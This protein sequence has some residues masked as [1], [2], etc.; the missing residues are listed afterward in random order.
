M[1]PICV[2]ILSL[3][4]TPP[5]PHTRHA[6]LLDQLHATLVKLPDR[7]LTAPMIN[8]TLFP[9]T[10]ILRQSA[11]TDLPD[12]FLEAVFRVLS[13]LVRSWRALDGGMDLVAWEQLWRFTTACIGPGVGKGKGKERSQ[14]VQLEAVNLLTALLEPSGTQD[15]LNDIMRAKFSTDRSPLMPTLFQ[16]I[17]LLLATSSPDPP[18]LNLQLHS[19][20]LLRHCIRFLKGQHRVLASVLP[21]TVSAMSR[22]VSSGSERIKGDVAVEVAGVVEEVIIITVNDHDLRQL[23][24]LQSRVDDLSQLGEETTKADPQAE[25]PRPS[26]PKDP[27]PPLTQ[28]YLSFTST[29]LA[30]VVP[31][32][33]SLSTHQSSAARLAVSSLAYGLV[34]LCSESLALDRVGL[35]TLL[36]LSKDEF[37]TVRSDAQ[38]KLRQLRLNRA[39]HI[40]LVDILSSSL[41]SLPRLI[42]SQQ[43]EKAGS[44]ARLITALAETDVGGVIADLLGPHGRVER[45]GW[46]LL[47]CLEF[48]KPTGS[49]VRG[50][51][52][53]SN[54]G[55][56]GFPHLPLR[57]VESGSTTRELSTMLTSLGS[58][59]GEMALNSVEHFMLFAKAHRGSQIA[60][61][62]SALWVADRL[63]D[64][65]ALA[66]EN[67]IDGKVSKAVRKMAR[68]VARTATVLDEDTEDT[69]F[70]MPSEELVPIERTTG[71][72]GVI[73]LFEKATLADSHTAN[74]T[75]KLHHQAQRTLL[76]C[77]SLSL[78]STS[79]R[80]LTTSFRTLLLNSLYTLLSHLGSQDMVAEYADIALAHVAY[81]AGYASVQNLVLDNVD[82]VINVVSQRLTYRRLDSQAPLV[83]IAM[84]RLVGDEIVPMVHDVVDEIFDALDDYHGYEALATSLLSVLITLI[85]VM[86]AEVQS[87]GISPERLAKKAEMNRMPGPPDPE[88]D[89][90]KLRQWYDERAAR[91]QEQMDTI[92]ERAPK[93]WKKDTGEPVKEDGEGDG[94]TED[95][96]MEGEE[97][98]PPTRSQEVAIAI[99]SKSIYF[100]THPSPFLRARILGLVARATPVLASAN[101]E[102]ELLP[103][104][105]QAWV[106]IL[107]RL[108]D[109][110]PYVVTEAAEVIASLCEHVGD[111]MSRRVLDQAWPRMKILL[112]KQRQLDEKSALVTRPRHGGSITTT[113]KTANAVPRG[114]NTSYSVSH[115]LHVAVLR[116]ARF[117]AQEV[118]VTESV[119]WEMSL[120]FRHF[121]DSRS[122]ASIQ[123]RA[124][125]LYRALGKR[126]GDAV[127]VVLE[128]T[129]SSKGVWGYLAEESLD[130]A[131]NAAVLLE[132]I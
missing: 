15:H 65:I 130:I 25:S 109:S 86:N 81:N 24:L 5:T 39:I 60:K 103:S 102:A 106:G 74:T 105:D 117:I 127:W 95:R 121:L 43:D 1:K 17:T 42:M 19:L 38:D 33:L 107:N 100:L 80:I 113:N 96:T 8:Y 57:H 18:Y 21:G 58:A 78:L 30:S 67:G 27:F 112:D 51:Q 98:N 108:D 73:K 120:V 28:S 77:L 37:D 12:S 99:L 41:T 131:V 129:I 82:Y 89:F 119:L 10:S 124:M 34:A 72:N 115:R 101:R 50:A 104:I 79:S 111:F 92:L 54:G 53:I 7:S 63:L 36:Q 66:Q 76:D 110:E 20:R 56:P 48:G 83:L 75:R 22:L 26:S 44:T 87:A 35:T 62:V 94:S 31:T 123:E 2:A 97:P 6:S 23:G 45:W 55:L 70:D 116:T 3:T 52:S 4:S 64:G 125:D 118:P 61:A 85:D 91:N 69:G 11:P 40:T 49:F 13:V 114:T 68:D 47:S 29:Q 46:A 84:I 126:D 14:D 93:V 88:S 132:E 128:S 9:L 16:T 71:T 59:G 122:N 32:I 90:A